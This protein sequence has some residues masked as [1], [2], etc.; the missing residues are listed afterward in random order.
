MESGKWV[1][2]EGGW[3]KGVPEVVQGLCSGLLAHTVED[4]V[5][6]VG[7]WLLG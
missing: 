3:G 4:I 6:E 1:R 7:L 5:E 2:G